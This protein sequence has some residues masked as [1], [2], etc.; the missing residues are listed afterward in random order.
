MTRMSPGD[1]IKAVE[2]VS[3]VGAGGTIAPDKDTFKTCKSKTRK[4]YVKTLESGR[5]HCKRVLR[6]TTCLLRSVVLMRREL[7][8]DRME[9][10]CAFES[11]LFEDRRI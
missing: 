10:Q 11:V 2:G 5:Y 7:V 8:D 3:F 9:L 6:W 4:I 1:V